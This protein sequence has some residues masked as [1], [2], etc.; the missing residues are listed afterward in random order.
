MGVLWP[1]FVRWWHVVVEAATSPGA[2]GVLS[3]W[4]TGAD[5]CACQGWA[6]TGQALFPLGV[7]SRAVLRRP[8]AGGAFPP[9]PRKPRV[10]LLFRC[11]NALGFSSA[12]VFVL[13]W[14]TRNQVL[15]EPQAQPSL[16][17][18]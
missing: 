6:V 10:T 9:P 14:E 12:P 16:P 3:P 7:C 11:F 2:F 1:E 5:P 17:P 13:E 15:M 18:T 8:V 4:G